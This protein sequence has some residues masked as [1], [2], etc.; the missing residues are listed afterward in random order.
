MREMDQAQTPGSRKVTGKE[1]L[2]TF[3]WV[4]WVVAGLAVTQL[5]SK[6]LGG[7]MFV[8]VALAVLF[9]LWRLTPEQSGQIAEAMDKQARTPFGQV[10]RIV[11]IALIL[12]VLVAVLRWAY[13]QLS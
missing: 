3:V 4:A 11:N 7:L 13:G 12:M 6:L 10:M 5:Y 8:P 9:S 2:V 1:L